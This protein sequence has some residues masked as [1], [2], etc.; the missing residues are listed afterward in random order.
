MT[1]ASNGKNSTAQVENPPKPPFA[2]SV[3]VVGHRPDRLPEKNSVH[4]TNLVAEVTRVLAEISREAGVI[5]SRYRDFFEAKSQPTTLSL[6][7]ALAEGADTIAAKAARS[8]GYVIDIVLPF[9]KQNYKED[10][11]GT[12]LDDFR[13]LCRSARSR[14]ALPGTRSLPPRPNDPE[15]NK[16]YEAAGLTVIGNSDILLA[17]W[18]SGESGGQGGTTE[19]LTAAAS[20]GIPII[21]VDAGG[22]KPTRVLWSNLSKFPVPAEKLQS[23]PDKTFDGALPHLMDELVRLPDKMEERKGLVRH[24]QEPF[25]DWHWALAFP[26]L[27]LF[28]AVRPIAKTEIWPAELDTLSNELLKLLTPAIGKKSSPSCRARAYAWADAIGLHFAQVFRS[29]FVVNFLIASLAVAAALTSLLTTRLWPVGVEIVLILWVI[30]ITWLGRHYGWHSRWVE[31]R[32]VAERLRVAAMLW[33]LGI[34]P[35]AFAGEEP[36]WTG[37]YARAMVR[38]Q[39]LRGGHLDRAAVDAARAATI[40]I[41]EN[42]RD[43]HRSNAR[44]MK[45]LERHLEWIGLIM[46]GATVLVAVDHLFFHEAVLRCLLHGGLPANRV[47]IAL[48][49]ILPAFATATY[50]IRVIGDFEGIAKRSERSIERLED[51]IAALRQ[52][53]P[54]L[55]ILRQRAR[56][57]GEAMLGDVSSWR[58]AVESRGLAIP[59]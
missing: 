2:L 18:D 5:S 35:R 31:P 7:T 22:A 30:A 12:A 33:V 36:T 55:D 3:G 49:A 41:L 53:P 1:N 40:N 11:S 32:E 9:A 38:A 10:F 19:I 13:D 45:R 42:Q 6:V 46:F 47:A 26:L 21:H 20:L 37:W 27:K 39:A 4:Y 23:L 8:C 58:L 34:R 14:L 52:D 57:A 54:D 51:H 43:Y 59:G 44:R 50:G 56:A 28:L 29:A 48:S 25:R 16:A 17:I 15:A 24:L